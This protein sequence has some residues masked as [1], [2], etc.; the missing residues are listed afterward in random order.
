[1][2][3]KICGKDML[4]SDVCLY[5]GHKLNEQK[6]N[7]ANE[8]KLVKGVEQVSQDVIAEAKNQINSNYVDFDGRIILEP[9]KSKEKNNEKNDFFEE[10]NLLIIGMLFFVV[11]IILNIVWRF[12]GFSFGAHIQ[13][14]FMIIATIFVLTGLK[15]IDFCKEN[16]DNYIKILGVIVPILVMILPI[17]LCYDIWYVSGG[18]MFRSSGNGFINCVNFF[19]IVCL[20]LSI[21]G[22]IIGLICNIKTII[23]NQKNENIKEKNITNIVSGVGLIFT[24]LI[25]VNTLV[26]VIF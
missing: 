16:K 9:V 20:I 6:A 26:V 25:I 5:C 14:I 18:A 1:M 8:I 23:N 4:R 10:Y 2:F 19:N 22:L 7:P 3:C 17:F 15:K 12:V 21:L 11:T 24:A 13:L